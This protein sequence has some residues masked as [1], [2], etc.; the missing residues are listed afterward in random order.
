MPDIENTIFASYLSGLGNYT[1]KDVTKD[2]P[3][4]NFLSP[5]SSQDFTQT[6]ALDRDDNISETQTRHTNFQ[7]PSL[8][9]D[10]WRTLSGYHIVYYPSFSG[11][12]FSVITFA[13]VSGSTMTF[14]VRV[15]NPT[16]VNRVTPSFT[17]TARVFLFVAPF[18]S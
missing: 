11:A 8:G 16:D 9:S 5:F 2:I 15:S 4:I 3:V 10:V 12:T 17:F 18:E 14:V 13:R 1:T 7:S 6:L